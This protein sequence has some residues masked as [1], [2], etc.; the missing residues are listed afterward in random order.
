MLVVIFN[1][2]H[3]PTAQAYEERIA[4]LDDDTR[5]RGSPWSSSRPTTLPRSGSTSWA[6]PTSSDSFEDMKIR[7]RDHKFALPLPLRR[8]DPGDGESLW[9]PCHAPRLSS[10]TPTASSATSAGSTTRT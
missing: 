8:R 10:S 9:R 2:N 6:T 4:R 5:G 3:C 1:C 7:A